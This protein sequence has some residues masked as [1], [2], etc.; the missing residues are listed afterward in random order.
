M[1][2][3]GRLVAGR[4]RLLE[5]IGRGGM[6]T[7]WRAED[8]LLGRQVAVKV[9]HAQ[10]YALDEEFATLFERTRREARAAASISHPNVVVVH[11]V[12]DDDGMPAI[13]MEYV[14]S[15]TLSEAL[16][17]S[18]LLPV[19]ETA[20]VG[21]AMLSA[22]RAA[23]AAGVL[24]RDVKPGNVLLGR[25]GRVVLTDF[26]IAQA[27]GT[28][29]L[30]RTGEVI[31][32]ID[33]VPPE[34]LVGGVPPGPESDLWA[35]GATLYQCV[36]GQPPFR[37]DTA[38]ETAYAIVQAELP[39]PEH[40]GRL[41]PL[42]TGLLTR[43]V[44]QRFTAEQAEWLLRGVPGERDTA[45]A[46]QAQLAGPW[47]G[48]RQDTAPTVA[49]PPAAASP[50]VADPVAFRQTAQQTSPFNGVG[51]VPAYPPGGQAP[52]YPPGPVPGPPPVFGATAPG[53]APYP[54]HPGPRRR[55]GW[56]AAAVVAAVLLVGSGVY[57]LDGFPGMSPVDS[58]S[59]TTSTRA[60]TTATA[61]TP[62]N[63]TSATPSPGTFTQP[64]TLSA[65]PSATASA[66]WLPPSVPAGYQ[67]QDEPD[68]GFEMPV[69]SGWTRQVTRSGQEVRYVSP[70]GLAG[71]RVGVTAYAGLTPLQNWQNIESQTAA[72]VQDY[73]RLNMAPTT[74][75]GEP[76][77]LWEFTFQGS[78]KA[79]RAID[80]GFGE[81]G[82]TQ[83]AVY[84]SAP[85][86]QWSQYQPIF[87]VA[88]QGFR[89][90]R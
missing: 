85:A 33:F 77:A 30:T 10:A 43:E 1:S 61:S 52:A 78:T 47:P 69:P 23:H 71:L 80:L 39:A 28:S 57:A 36:E 25:D 8:E 75:L 21:R 87:D 32:S 55:A 24:H 60:G 16:K 9:L 82:G 4:Y 53:P 49:V 34:R 65:T 48:Q 14:P 72:K 6:G 3:E 31:G 89:V 29:Q 26:G 88:T 70:D 22:L 74:W 20:R 66:S 44:K 62:G 45:V 19:E 37:R 17:K 54:P 56:A 59:A 83:Y 41:A 64:A 58:P 73:Q 79:W 81:T 12:V 13:V 51:E 63:G 76:A 67:L 2:E 7:V 50:G 15:T 5:R 18:G 68:F 11:D 46:D 84:L 35:L 27:A 42:I 90:T 86:G 38:M 40:A